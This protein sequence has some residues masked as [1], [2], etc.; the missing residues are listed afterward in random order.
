MINFIIPEDN[1]LTKVKATFKV[2]SGDVRMF[3]SVNESERVF[4]GWLS[5]EGT[6]WRALLSEK[7]AG[8]LRDWG[9]K[10][11]HDKDRIALGNP[12]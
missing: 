9:F 10:L 12:D 4:I 11:N 8:Y 5:S 2:E 6:L 7:E 3:L 1:P